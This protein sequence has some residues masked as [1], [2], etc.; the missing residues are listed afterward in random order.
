MT[1]IHKT[2]NGFR[3]IT[4]GAPDILIGKCNKDYNNGDVTVLN[5]TRL[6]QIKSVNKAMA[7]KALRVLAVA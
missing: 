7:E 6:K 2:S 1:T 4:K 5:K 3:I